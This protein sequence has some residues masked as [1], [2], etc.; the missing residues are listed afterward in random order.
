MNNICNQDVQRERATYDMLQLHY[1][2]VTRDNKNQ[3]ENHC[4]LN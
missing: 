1:I 4:K 2:I 3:T